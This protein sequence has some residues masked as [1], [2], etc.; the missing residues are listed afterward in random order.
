MCASPVTTIDLTADDRIS[1]DALIE[2]LHSGRAR[3]D[4]PRFIAASGVSAHS[5]PLGLRRAVDEFRLSERELALVI[6]GLGIEDA[7]IGATPSHWDV[8]QEGNLAGREEL[9][10]ALV[11]S[12]LGDLFAW[13]TLQ[14][15][16]VVMNVL[17]VRGDEGTQTGHG[18]VLLEWHTEDAFHPF[19][20]DYLVS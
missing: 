6:R 12:L 5:L 9:Y 1:I 2:D 7:K 13:S 20:C 17:P 18:T 19:R 11:A 10:L 8:P 3:A 15:G 16:R 4:D 14:R